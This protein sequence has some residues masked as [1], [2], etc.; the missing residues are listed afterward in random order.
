MG[1]QAAPVAER[2]CRAGRRPASR[3]TME[4]RA[5]KQGVVR[6][7]A[8]S[9]HWRSRFHTEMGANLSERGLDA[10]AADEPGDDLLRGSVEIGAGKA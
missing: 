6:A 7:M 10:P 9:D 2:R 8:R 3:V 4:N 1:Y 5:K